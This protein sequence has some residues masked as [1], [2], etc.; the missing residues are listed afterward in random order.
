MNSY[1]IEIMRQKWRYLTVLLVLLIINLILFF[2][3]SFY[4]TPHLDGL[5]TKW[6]ELRNQ[7]ARS[8]KIDN[9]ALHQLAAA[10]LEKLKTHIPKKR[11]FA[12]V[13]SSLIES[14]SSNAVDIG[15][16]SYKPVVIKE[17]ALLSYQLTL[18][19][20]GSYAA[21]KSF[22]ADLQ[23]SNELLIV[24]SVSFSNSD[25]FVENV[26]MNLQITVYLQEGV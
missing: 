6:S 16:I 20:N 24:D 5:Q 17:E 18:A 15:N 23:S 14:A 4:Q 22:L 9:L 2:V 12:K 1:L 25:A 3:K 13:L 8:G 19:A 10:N 11:E 26:L 7:S 21:V